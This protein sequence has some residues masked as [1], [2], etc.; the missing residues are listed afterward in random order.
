VVKPN[1]TPDGRAIPGLDWH[2]RM[3]SQSFLGLSLS[4]PT[5]TTEV[6][7]GGNNDATPRPTLR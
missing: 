6:G 4:V 5:S 2:G 1:L 3:T 7:G